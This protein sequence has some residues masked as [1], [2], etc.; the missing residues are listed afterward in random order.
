MVRQA[1]HPEQ[2]RRIVIPI[3]S[4]MPK[5]PKFIRLQQINS[6]VVKTAYAVV[7]MAYATAKTWNFLDKPGPIE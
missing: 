7:E 1:H 3:L 6:R 5:P 2:G 4:A